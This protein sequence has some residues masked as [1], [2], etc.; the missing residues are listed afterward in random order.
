MLPAKYDITVYQGDTF[1]LPI[2]LSMK[3]AEEN[4]TPVDL[5]DH[6]LKAQ[7]RQRQ[8]PDADLMG[9]FEFVMLNP[10]QG[11]FEAVLPAEESAN[12]FRNGFW[13]LET[14]DLSTGEVRTWIHGEVTVLP[15]V[16]VWSQDD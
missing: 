3:D 15:Q 10:E 13:D 2:T 9:T 6:H 16:T 5:T 11:S 12:V 4:V 7:I 8:N 1:R 14:T